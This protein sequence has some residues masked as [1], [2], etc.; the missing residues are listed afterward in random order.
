MN[1]TT[2]TQNW[3]DIIPALPLARGVPYVAA[4]GPFTWE[5]PYR[6]VTGDVG[7]EDHAR[8]AADSKVRVDLADPVGF[9]YALRYLYGQFAY[10]DGEQSL[11]REL[12]DRCAWGNTTDADRL[13]LAKMLREVMA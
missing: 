8:L 4:W 13:A 12:W 10:T 11:Y 7:S 3:I 1:T 2:L 5:R 6:G 9:A